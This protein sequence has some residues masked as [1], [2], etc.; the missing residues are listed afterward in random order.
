M[1]STI[2]IDHIHH[3]LNEPKKSKFAY[4]SDRREYIVT[5]FAIRWVRGTG[6]WYAV[7]YLARIRY[8]GGYTESVRL[9]SY[10]TS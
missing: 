9:G 4:N 6:T 2:N 8:V 7:R 3:L 1:W 5:R 10:Y